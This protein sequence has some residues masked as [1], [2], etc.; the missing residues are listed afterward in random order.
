MVVLDL[1]PSRRRPRRLWLATALLA[2]RY[3]CIPHDIRFGFQIF[4]S[5]LDDVANADDADE[6]AVD[7]NGQMPH[8]MI[9]HQTHRA[10]QA[11]GGRNRDH[12]AGTALIAGAM[13][14]S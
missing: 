2:R 5:M 7:N 9:R 4:Q 6:L 12:G 11:I 13:V 14:N 1:V 3:L 10:L 8:A